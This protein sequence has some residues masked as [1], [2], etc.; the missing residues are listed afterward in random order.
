MND[1][2]GSI[3]LGIVIGALAAWYITLCV[4]DESDKKMQRKLV[5]CGYAEWVVADDSLGTTEFALKEFA[6]KEPAK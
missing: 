2:F 6:L 4:W 5:R 1:D 3:C